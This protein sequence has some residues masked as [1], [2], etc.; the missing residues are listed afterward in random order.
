MEIAR[1]YQIHQ[2]TAWFFKRKV[3]QAMASGSQPL[4]QGFVEVDET[5]IGG[6][7]KDQPGRSH[8]KKQMVE[9][10]IELT[11]TDGKPH[12]LQV[13]NAAARVIKDYSAN[14]LGAGIE[15]MVD[16][17]ADICTDQWSAYPKA[18]AERTHLTFPSSEGKNFEQLHWHIFNLKNWIRGTHH[19]VSAGYM[20]PYLDEFHYR[21]NRRNQIQSCPTRLLNRMTKAMKM[22]RQMLVYE[23]AR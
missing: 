6:M 2:S 16:K 4:L 10:A 9:V 11:V 1:Q 17:E 12:K 22:P 13:K 7:E 23:V 15:K 18:V 20:Q 19:K 14:E 8:G 3:Q 5:V 21:F